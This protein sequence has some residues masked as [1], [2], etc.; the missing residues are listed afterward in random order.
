MSEAA[1]PEPLTPAAL[2]DFADIRQDILDA[3][4]SGVVVYEEVTPSSFRFIAANAFVFA[5]S[6]FT[7]A[8]FGR[9]LTELFP[10]EAAE[11]Q[12]VNMQTCLAQQAPVEREERYDL[13]S[14]M[15]WLRSSYRPL[16]RRPGAPQRVMIVGDNITAHKL[17]EQARADQESLI[18]LQAL[19]LAELSTPLLALSDTTMVMPLVGAIDSPRIQ[20]IMEALLTGVAK[21]SATHVILD[22]TGVPIVDTQVANAL[23]SAAQ[24]VTLLG[25][26]TVLTGIRPEVA[27]TLVGLGANLS[28]IVTRGTLQDGI[29]YAFQ[30]DAHRERLK[31]SR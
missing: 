7:P 1:A 15:L 10:P 9:L 29:G 6:H 14:G 28:S 21:Q 23:L 4:P 12:L 5:S 11:R 30:S 31:R 27:Q 25:A 3:L 26:E 22:I 19:Q 13:S 8:D 2:R 24:A 16:P 20:Q 18:E 17:A